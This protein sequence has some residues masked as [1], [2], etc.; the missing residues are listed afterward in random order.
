MAT[1]IIDRLRTPA[2][3]EVLPL[4]NLCVTGNAAAL[5]QLFLGLLLNAAQ[6]TERAGS[7]GI[8]VDRAA[9][10]VTVTLWDT[11]PGFLDPD[12]SSIRRMLPKRRSASRRAD[13]PSIPSASS[14][15]DLNSKS[16]RSSS[17]TSSSTRPGPR[18]PFLTAPL[19][20]AGSQPPP[21]S[22]HPSDA[23]LSPALSGRPA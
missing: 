5:E 15:R 16:W 4:S 12:C 10:S 13:A 23:P 14:S 17:A 7:I 22:P 21:P 19:R 11:G 18:F 8:E 6:A 1:A 9:G 3:H 2:F 20:R